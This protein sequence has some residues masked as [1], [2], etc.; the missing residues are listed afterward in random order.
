MKLMDAGM[1]CMRL[2][3]SHGN[4]KVGDSHSLTNIVV[5]CKDLEEVR[6]CPE[7]APSQALRQDD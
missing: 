3:L 2:N 1:A 5:K 7:V 6:R 4:N